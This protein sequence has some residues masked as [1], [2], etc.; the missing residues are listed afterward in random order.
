VGFVAANGSGDRSSSGAVFWGDNTSQNGKLR[1][2]RYYVD[3]GSI[4]NHNMLWMHNAARA[5]RPSQHSLSVIG[6][7]YKGV[8]FRAAQHV[9]S[10]SVGKRTIT[11]HV[12]EVLT[13][14]K[15][16]YTWVAYQ[17]LAPE[18]TL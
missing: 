18:D 14:I 10:L 12:I 15:G 11:Q 16:R 9:A 7:H 4:M 1:K 3:G 2:A 6:A 13:E 5:S 17:F 8:R